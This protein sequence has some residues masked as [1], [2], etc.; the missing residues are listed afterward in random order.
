VTFDHTCPQC[1]LSWNDTTPRNDPTSPDCCTPECMDAWMDAHPDEKLRRDWIT[2]QD[3]VDRM[4]DRRGMIPMS[5]AT[6]ELGDN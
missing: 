6:P 2:R 3:L 1:G 4:L 5:R